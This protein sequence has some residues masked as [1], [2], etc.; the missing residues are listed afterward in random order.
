MNFADQ[1]LQFRLQRPFAPF[2]VVLKDGSTITIT[3]RLKFAVNGIIMIAVREHGPAVKFRID[4]VASIEILE[5][6][7]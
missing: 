2:R 3:E 6:V 7:G 5:P 1:L 4:Q